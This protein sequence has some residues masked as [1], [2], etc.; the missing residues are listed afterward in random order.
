[1]EITKV[2]AELLASLPHANAS[3]TEDETLPVVWVEQD[4]DDG[5]T[6]SI[7]PGGR[8][9]PEDRAW[10][11]QQFA[12]CVEEAM[13]GYGI[14]VKSRRRTPSRAASPFKGSFNS[15]TRGLIVGSR[16]FTG[17]RS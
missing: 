6:M 9:E 17:F 3:P 13:E 4:G 1:M 16:L 10:L 14:E 11:W 5:W 2:I 8:L 7:Y 15:R 12:E